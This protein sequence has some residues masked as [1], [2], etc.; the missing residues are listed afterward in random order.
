MGDN[1]VYPLS[2]SAKLFHDTVSQY[3][4]SEGLMAI[5]HFICLD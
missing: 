4:E 1:A 5:M 2:R 3:K